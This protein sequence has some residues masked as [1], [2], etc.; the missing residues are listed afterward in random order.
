M[1][2][3]AL[4]FSLSINIPASFLGAWAYKLA[5]DAGRLPYCGVTNENIFWS[6]FFSI[7]IAGTLTILI[8]CLVAYWLK[9]R[10]WVF[11]V[12][13]VVLALIFHSGGDQLPLRHTFFSA[14]MLFG[15][16][17]PV[18]SA[19]LGWWFGNAIAAGTV[20][21]KPSDAGS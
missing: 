21:E 11:L 9:R 16:T 8:A 17:P 10:L 6:T 7:L 20:P 13:T 15:S 14:F 12:I 4:L 2:K 1:R 18:L 5:C 3:Y 19:A